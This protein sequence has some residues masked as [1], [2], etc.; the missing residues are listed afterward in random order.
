MLSRGRSGRR[1]RRGI[2]DGSRRSARQ[3]NLVRGD[4]LVKD[5]SGSESR[6]GGNSMKR[7]ICVVVTGSALVGVLGTAPAWARADH[8]ATETCGGAT[9]AV[10]DAHAGSSLNAADVK[11]NQVAGLVLGM[12]C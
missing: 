9:T 8:T 10:V 2:A 4:G 3:P 1:D 6:K 12:T 11:F 5:N 7:R